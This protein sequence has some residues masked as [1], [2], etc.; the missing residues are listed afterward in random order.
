[1]TQTNEERTA[2]FEKLAEYTASISQY[3]NEIQKAE[4]NK[5]AAETKIDGYK[6]EIK[7]LTKKIKDDYDID[8]DKIDEV[9]IKEKESLDKMMK[10]LQEAFGS[11]KEDS[12]QV[13]QS[14]QNAPDY[15]F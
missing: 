10:E 4:M 7:K 5:V 14:I 9:I 12:E 6:D 2:M 15:A 3:S 11:I 13:Q 1:M 8:V